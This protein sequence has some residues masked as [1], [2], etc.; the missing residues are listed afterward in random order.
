MMYFLDFDR[1]LFDTDT[2]KVD[3]AESI[4]VRKLTCVRG[5]LTR[6]L[7]PDVPE[8]L[9]A[10]GN[11]AVII[12]YGDAL[13]QRAKIESALAGIVRLT[14][15]Y[16]PEGVSKADFLKQWPGYHGAPACF[17]DDCVSEL[18]GMA[19]A[20]SHIKPYEMRRDGG[21]DDGRWPV[22]RS[23]FEVL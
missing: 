22:I 18:D 10:L 11:E 14:V 9:R 15:L 20:F 1:T 3:Y 5:E 4:A 16:D 7:Y 2:F 6:Y 21:S 13:W 23:L 12:T 8:I 17:V 19:A